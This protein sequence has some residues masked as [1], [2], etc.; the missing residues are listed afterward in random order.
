MPWG[1]AGGQNIEHPHTL[2]ILSSFFC[3]KCF[4]VLLAMRN[5]GK[6]RCPATAVIHL[7]FIVAVEILD[8]V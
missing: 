8:Y 7:Y 6:L 1:G 3:F 2:A 4:L 5:S